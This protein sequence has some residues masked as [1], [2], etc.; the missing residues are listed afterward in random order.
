MRFSS[1]APP[2]SRCARGGDDDDAS[3]MTSCIENRFADVDRQE[4][5]KPFGAFVSMQYI[6]FFD[7]RRDQCS[8]ASAQNC[9]DRANIIESVEQ[10]S[11]Q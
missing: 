11:L 4:V 10:E 2:P 1:D 9:Q 3:E 5:Y 7:F 8:A 6:D